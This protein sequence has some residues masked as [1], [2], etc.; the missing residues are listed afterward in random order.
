MLS[1]QGSLVNT[2]QVLHLIVI[3]ADII[4]RDV[5]QLLLG[6][7]SLE[8]NVLSDRDHVAF[9]SRYFWGVGGVWSPVRG[10]R[11]GWGN[12]GEWIAYF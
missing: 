1:D 12:F 10:I 7:P 3:K 9:L 6:T 4:Q 8:V 2:D 5:G 11:S